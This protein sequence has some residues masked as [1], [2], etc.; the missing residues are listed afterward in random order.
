MRVRKANRLNWIRHAARVQVLN[1]FSREENLNRFAG[2]FLKSITHHNW[3]PS[4]E[5]PILQQI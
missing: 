4:H 1:N 3:S 2:A 5:N